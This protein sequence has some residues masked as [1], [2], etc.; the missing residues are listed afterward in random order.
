M[1]LQNI[2]A[3]AARCVDIR[4]VDFG[5]ERDDRGFEWIVA[6]K[7]DRHVEDAAREGRVCGTEDHGVPGKEVVVFDGARRTIGGRVIL[8]FEQFTLESSECHRTGAQPAGCGV[9]FLSGPY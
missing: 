4:M 9:K 5:F 3:D 6:G 2:K 8:D 1:S 7:A